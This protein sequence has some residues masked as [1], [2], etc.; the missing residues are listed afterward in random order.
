MVPAYDKGLPGYAATW[1]IRRK[2]VA[3]CRKARHME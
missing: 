1:Q 2:N 3:V